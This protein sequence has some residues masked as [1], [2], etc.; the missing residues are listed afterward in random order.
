MNRRPRIGLVLGAGA[1][2]GFAHIGALKV[3]EKEKIKIDLIAGCSMGAIIGGCYALG[4]KPSIMEEKA[5]ELSRSDIV[6]IK[7][8]N[9]FGFVKGDRAE[10]V[11]RKF[12]GSE[13]D[14]EL[15]FKDCKIPFGCV[16]TDIY[17]AKLVNLTEGAIIPAIRA[18]FSIGAIF[19]PVNIDGK[20]LLD[21]G[22]LCR[23][24]VNLAKKMGADIVIAI[25]CI[26]KTRPVEEN[27]ISRYFDTINR[28]FYMMDYEVSKKEISK[29][30]VLIDIRSIDLKNVDKS[31]KYGEEA[32]KLAIPKIKE[33]IKNFSKKL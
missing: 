9:R 1:S 18:S 11:V 25:D 15:T 22:I 14:K 20:N 8:P 21:G 33:V 2:L 24:P 16:A 10:K 7:I 5:L 3:L 12:L 19:W 28:I 23:V 26:G 30:D 17:D 4:A 6:D 27:S 32:M 13:K 31:I 29:A